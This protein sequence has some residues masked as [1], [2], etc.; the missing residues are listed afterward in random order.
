[1]K[2][3]PIALIEDDLPVISLLAS[4]ELVHKSVNNLENAFV[5]FLSSI[6]FYGFACVCV[7]HPRIQKIRGGRDHHYKLYDD[8]H[9]K[10]VN[11][12][13]AKKVQLEPVDNEILNIDG[14]AKGY[15]PVKIEVLEKRLKIIN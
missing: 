2:H 3:G 11:Y 5:N 8:T 7:D 4:D 9:S 6:P 14:D 13:T 1:M 10:F 12:S 15:T